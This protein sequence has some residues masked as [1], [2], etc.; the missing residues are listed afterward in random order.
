MGPGSLVS[1]RGYSPSPEALGT[2]G[3]APGCPRGNDGDRTDLLFLRALRLVSVERLFLLVEVF[4][5]PVARVVD[6]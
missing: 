3:A 1:I 5:R 4:Q 2:C 6:D